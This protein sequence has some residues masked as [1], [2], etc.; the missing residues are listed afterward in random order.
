MD[1]NMI[2]IARTEHE[3]RNRR[4]YAR[5]PAHLSMSAPMRRTLANLGDLLIRI[6]SKLK[7][8]HAPMPRPA[9]LQEQG[10]I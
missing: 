4:T 10:Q 7:A 3:A 9:A 6:G 1:Y 8:Q 2:M 5:R